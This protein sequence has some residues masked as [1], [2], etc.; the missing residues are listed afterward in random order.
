[1]K[2]GDKAALCM[3]IVLA[4]LLAYCIFIFW[5]HFTGALD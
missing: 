4:F 3:A 1:M 5:L 2:T